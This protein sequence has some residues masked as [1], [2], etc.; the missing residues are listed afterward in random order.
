MA[1]RKA[2]KR[3]AAPVPRG[4]TEP[5][6][7]PPDVSQLFAEQLSAAMPNLVSQISASILQNLGGNN[8]RNAS[9]SGVPTLDTVGLGAG[10]GG[11]IVIE[12]NPRGCSYKTFMG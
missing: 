4:N 11:T 2:R 6:N 1:P 7:V 8:N 12:D 3:R 10:T 5:N 9:G